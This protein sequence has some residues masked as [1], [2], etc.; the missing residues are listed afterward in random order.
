MG[1]PWFIFTDA[2]F[3]PSNAD[4]PCGIGGVLI[5]PDGKQVA[6]FSFA[7]DFNHLKVLGYPRKKTVIFEAELLALIVAMKL[8]SVFI[9]Q[10]PCM[11]FIDNNAAR[12]IAISGHA[13]T[14]PGLTLAGTL[15]RLEDA[16]AVIAWYARVASSSN[17][18]DAPSRASRDGILVPYVDDDLVSRTLDEVLSQITTG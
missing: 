12:D 11:F 15:L 14:E 2:S 16:I 5:G 17:I 18:A 1:K 3:E 9:A 7:L 10:Q 8:W 4:V 6:A 13:R